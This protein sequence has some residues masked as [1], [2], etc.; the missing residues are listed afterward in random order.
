MNFLLRCSG[1][2][3]VAQSVKLLTSA[4]VMISPPVGSSP[5][6]GS[7]LTARGLEPASDSGSPS[8][9]APPP[10]TLCPSKINKKNHNRIYHS[11]S[12][13]QNLAKSPTFRLKCKSKS[14]QVLQFS[15]TFPRTPHCLLH[16]QSPCREEARAAARREPMASLGRV[17]GPHAEP[18]SHLS[19]PESP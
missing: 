8:L 7:V 3:W 12:S 13:A 4:Q 1:G 14:L 6:L 16:P 17:G 2:A 18:S 10:L 19:A 5:V 15:W 9:S 11:S